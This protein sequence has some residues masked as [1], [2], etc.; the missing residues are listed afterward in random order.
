MYALCI[1]LGGIL[2]VVVASKLWKSRGET[3][4]T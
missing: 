3:L 2:A 4:R 1:V